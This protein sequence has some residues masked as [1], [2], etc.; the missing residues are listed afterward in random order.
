MGFDAGQAKRYEMG[1][2]SAQKAKG[3]QSATWRY[4]HDM[5]EIM[6]LWRAMLVPGGT[7]CLVVGDGQHGEGVIHT[8][9]VLMRAAKKSGLLPVASVSQR[10]R[11]YGKARPGRRAGDGG[12]LKEEHI[13]ALEVPRG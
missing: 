10:R 2:R 9:P 8:L 11:I 4:E 5:A 1:S 13:F 3:W 6:S 7:I 12:T